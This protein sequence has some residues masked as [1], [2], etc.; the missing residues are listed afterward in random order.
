MAISELLLGKYH[1]W[2]IFGLALATEKQSVLWK[3]NL[4]DE[5]H[6]NHSAKIGAVS[7]AENTPDTSKFIRSIVPIGPKV[8]DID[9]E[10]LHWASVVRGLCK[11]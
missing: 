8:W 4:N 6:G 11:T 5:Y 1:T 9:E 3:K 10:R 2:D 7:S